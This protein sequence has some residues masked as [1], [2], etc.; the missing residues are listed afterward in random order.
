MEVVEGGR[1]VCS[2]TELR[3]PVCGFVDDGANGYCFFV[4]HSREEN[5]EIVLCEGSNHLWIK[6]TSFGWV[7]I[8]AHRRDDAN[9]SLV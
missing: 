5:G 8:G 7:D 1:K 3:C 2:A 9:L 6:S 4:R